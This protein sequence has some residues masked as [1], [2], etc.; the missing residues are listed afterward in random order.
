MQEAQDCVY[1]PIGQYNYIDCIEPLGKRKE[2][3]GK[4]GFAKYLI[5]FML[6]V[7]SVVTRL[8]LQEER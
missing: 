2:V 4:A 1:W 6:N 5:F 7:N 3:G 8:S